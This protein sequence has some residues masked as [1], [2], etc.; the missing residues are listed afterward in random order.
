[1]KNLIIAL[2]VYFLLGLAPMEVQAQSRQ[3]YLDNYSHPENGWLIGGSVD[4]YIQTGKHQ[5]YGIKLAFSTDELLDKDEYHPEPTH[6]TAAVS[7]VNNYQFKHGK[8]RRFSMEYGPALKYM[9][10]TA[11]LMGYGYY[12]YDFGR[13]FGCPTILLGEEKNYE[14]S[15]GLTAGLRYDWRIFGHFNIGLALDANWMFNFVDEK[16][17]LDLNPALSIGYGW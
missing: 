2:S 10:Q 17:S 12:Y 4:Y 7:L 14:L 16:K 3:I 8:R 15:V 11:F 1:M 13:C 9:E 5:Y 6:K